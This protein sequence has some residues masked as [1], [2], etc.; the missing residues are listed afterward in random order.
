M[1]EISRYEPGYAVIRPTNRPVKWEDVHILRERLWNAKQRTSSNCLKPAQNFQSPTNSPYNPTIPDGYVSIPGTKGGT[2]WRE[3]GTTGNANTIRIMPPTFQYPN[4]Y[5]RQYNSYG[6]PIN[7]S[8]GK[9]GPANQT[10]I[11][12]P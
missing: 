8:T 12:L 7:P 6:Q 4:G 9:P 5:W 2:I 1:N 3:P 10:H 11:P